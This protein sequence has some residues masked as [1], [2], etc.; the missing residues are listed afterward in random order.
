MGTVEA[1]YLRPAAR[2]P[3]REVARAVAI[4]GQGLDGDHAVGGRRQVTILS[5]EAWRAACGELGQDVDPRVRR[6]NVVV[7]G[8]DLRRAIGRR[9]RL[10]EVEVDV[11]GETRPC[12][13]MD[14]DGRVGLDAAL[15]R[16]RRGGVFGV[17]ELGGVI[18]R[19]DD[20]TLVD[21]SR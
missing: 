18:A 8:V 1:I 19:G 14:D 4:Q 9:L 5:L 3:T 7:A 2:V 15:R 20:V 6:A 11:L 21:P 16:D 12:E 13:L 17:V 10:G